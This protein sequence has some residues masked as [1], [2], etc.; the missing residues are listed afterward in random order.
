[1]TLYISKT[2]RDT[3]FNAFLES[4]GVEVLAQPMILF[5]LVNFTPPQ[6]GS[7]SVI[8]FASPRAVKFF[9]QTVKINPNAKIGTIGKSTSQAVEAFGYSVDFEGEK[10]GDPQDISN[11]FSEFVGNQKVLFPQSTRS[12]RSIQRFLSEDQVI[13]LIVYKTTLNP[14][15]IDHKPSI[16]VFTSP[17]NAEAFLE[18]NTIENQQQ[19]IIA[20]GNTTAGFLEKEGLS[21][22]KT[23]KNSNVDE[24]TKVLKQI[25]S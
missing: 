17:S 6:E 18:K 20:W 23:L 11:V 15:K 4:K 14:I 1:M 9:L 5:D 19:K 2:I 10:S 7:Y 16:L 22:F 25:I 24:L 13:N 8:F 21:V 3:A 12:H